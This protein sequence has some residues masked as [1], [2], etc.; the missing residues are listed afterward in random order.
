[1]IPFTFPPGYDA[2]TRAHQ[3][4]ARA[5]SAIFSA[6]DPATIVEYGGADVS[7][8]T[9]AKAVFYK[10]LCARRLDRKGMPDEFC[11]RVFK[12]VPGATVFEEVPLQRICTGRGQIGIHLTYD[13]R[14][15]LLATWRWRA[16]EGNHDYG[17][18]IPGFEPFVITAVDTRAFQPIYVGA[19]APS[20]VLYHGHYVPTDL[21]EIA[22]LVLRFNKLLDAVNEHYEI[23][24]HIGAVVE[25]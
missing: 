18:V 7:D 14:G 23:L 16:W 13:D 15:R 3:K 12:A 20:R 25:V 5:Q 8:G 19:Q 21:D 6:T 4:R 11:F 10:G 17:D 2:G 9:D 1:M 22:E 24:R